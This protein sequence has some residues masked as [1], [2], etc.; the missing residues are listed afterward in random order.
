MLKSRFW[1]EQLGG[2]NETKG[3][4]IGKEVKLCLFEDDMIVYMELPK[5]FTK[6]YQ[7]NQFQQ[8]FRIQDLY[9]KPIVFLYNSNEQT[10]IKRKKKRYLQQNKK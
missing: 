3:I 7:N 9:T 10:K 8:G 4:Q 2:K 5:Y 1:P 6:N